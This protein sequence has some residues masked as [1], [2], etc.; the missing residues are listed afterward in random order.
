M[1]PDPETIHELGSDVN[2][3]A[4][5]HGTPLMA[6][7]PE[8]RDFGLSLLIGAAIG[9]AISFTSSVATQAATVGWSNINWGIKGVLGSTIVGAVSG[10][11]S[12]GRRW[13]QFVGPKSGLVK[14]QTA[15][16]NWV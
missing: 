9:A 6:I 14:E 11:V 13:T 1:S 5:V 2:P 12:G 7:D 4:Y 8:G 16:N 15:R 10:A 3:Y